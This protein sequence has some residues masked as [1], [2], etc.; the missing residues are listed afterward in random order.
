M[1]AK[2][3]PREDRRYPSAG[4]VDGSRMSFCLA[5]TWLSLEVAFDAASTPGLTSGPTVAIFVYYPW[6]G[7]Y[8]APFEVWM[9]SS[10][11]ELSTQCEVDGWREP[12][13][14]G[15]PTLARCPAAAS[16]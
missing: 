14:G 5:A 16:L 1:S 12:N 10:P 9:G 3:G 13:P 4:C 6:G 2:A 15:V 8:M 11:A 7:E